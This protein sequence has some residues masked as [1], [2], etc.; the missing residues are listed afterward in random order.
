MVRHSRPL[1]PQGRVVL[2]MYIV[3]R[4]ASGRK[5]IIELFT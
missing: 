2:L 4:I 3:S 5:R 1:G